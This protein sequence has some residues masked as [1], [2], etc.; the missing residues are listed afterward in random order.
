MS[1][2]IAEQLRKQAEDQ[3]RAER[4]LAEE[5]ARRPPGR[6]SLTI[7]PASGG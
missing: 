3:Q 1:D 7:P 5:I 4:Q 2:D 6:R